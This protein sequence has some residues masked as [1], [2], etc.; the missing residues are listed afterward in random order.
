MKTHPTQEQPKSALYNS[1]MLNYAT[2]F[3]NPPFNT[4]AIQCEKPHSKH[5]THIFLS[6][7]TLK[8]IKMNWSKKLFKHTNSRQQQ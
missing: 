6:E 7:C 4:S 3:G 1:I 8:V 5:C 2:S